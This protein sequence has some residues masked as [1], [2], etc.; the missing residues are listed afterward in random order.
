MVDFF[1]Q[2]KLFYHV[3]YFKSLMELETNIKNL[4]SKRN[5]GLDGFNTG[6]YQTFKEAIIPNTP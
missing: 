4:Q 6:F 5:T 3:N 1:N 2:V